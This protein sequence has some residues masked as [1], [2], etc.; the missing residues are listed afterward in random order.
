MITD[1]KDPVPADEFDKL[2]EDESL[3]SFGAG[4]IP[5]RLM[6]EGDPVSPKPELAYEI[7]DYRPDSKEKRIIFEM[8]QIDGMT[9]KMACRAA[10]VGQTTFRKTFSREIH[11]AAKMR[12][13]MAPGDDFRP[14]TWHRHQVAA[15]V[16]TGL[17]EEK[18]CAIMFRGNVEISR[19]KAWFG[20]ELSLGADSIVALSMDRVASIVRQGNDKDAGLNA[21][22]VLKQ[23][24]LGGFRDTTRHDHDSHGDAKDKTTADQLAATEQAMVDELVESGLERAA[25]EIMIKE[26]SKTGK[27][28][29]SIRAN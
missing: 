8:L 4:D 11:E 16:A 9:I 14:M 18:I 19:F 26:L 27:G 24:G 6:S 13:Q 17:S 28:N 21:R 15:M 2:F 22:F 5:D 3:G 1:P 29:S 20:H 23:Q 7:T 12:A 10:G 25:A